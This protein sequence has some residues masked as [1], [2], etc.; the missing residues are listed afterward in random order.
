MLFNG[1]R[2]LVLQ[3]EKVLEIGCTTM[4]IYL[5]LLKCTLKNGQDGRF[6]VMCILPQLKEFFKKLVF[7]VGVY[8]QV[9]IYTLSRCQ[10]TTEQNRFL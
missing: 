8:V 10:R 5:T 7:C 4:G 1:Y 3:D 9:H 6:Y 2:V